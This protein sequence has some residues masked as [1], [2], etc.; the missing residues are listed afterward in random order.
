MFMAEK[1]AEWPGSSFSK[2]S[3]EDRWVFLTKHKDVMTVLQE[4][5]WTPANP[6]QNMD[7]LLAD[8]KS[9]DSKGRDDW[10]PWPGPVKYNLEVAEALRARGGAAPPERATPYTLPHPHLTPYK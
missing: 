7:V 1:P 3:D 8:K 4:R 5:A 9:G 6:P 10:R 2:K